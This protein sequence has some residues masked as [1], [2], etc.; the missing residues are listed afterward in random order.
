[1]I[2]LS[3][4]LRSLDAIFFFFFFQDDNIFLFKID[5]FILN[6]YFVILFFNQFKFDIDFLV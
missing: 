3:I 2:V 4:S 1:M 5:L 6:L